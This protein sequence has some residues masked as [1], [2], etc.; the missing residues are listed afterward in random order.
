LP[1]VQN[2]FILTHKGQCIRFPVTDAREIGRTGRGVTGIRF[3]VEGDYVVGAA[4]IVSDEQELLTVSE[5][6]I[7]KRTEAGEYRLQS[8][9]GK[10]VVA[11]KLTN[12][13]GN[14]VGVVIVEENKDL[15]VLTQS[16][17]MIRVDMH[18][19]RK[20]GRNTSG[21]M[22]V[23]LDSG[24]KVNSIAVCPKEEAEEELPEEIPDMLSN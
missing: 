2:L 21:V 11:M 14:A 6:G 8:R 16:G 1:E 22:I 23:R 3:K 9:G 17:K 15:M 13:T 24:D 19:I 18:Q 10:G 7:G 12:R 4:T 5:K 20:A